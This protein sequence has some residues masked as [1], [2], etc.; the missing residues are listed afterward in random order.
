MRYF[1]PWSLLT[2]LGTAC[3]LCTAA[4]AKPSTASLTGILRDAASNPVP[5]AAIT[6]HAKSGGGSYTASTSASGKFKFPEL[7][8]G[9]YQVS[10]A[11]PAE[12]RHSTTDLAVKAGITLTATFQFSSQAQDVRI[13]S[14]EEAAL[15]QA[16]GGE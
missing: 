3:L 12:T 11:T 9:D 10:V 7:P 6:L 16:T 4:M 1:L 13:S 15:P 8:P 14:G 5:Q 2:L